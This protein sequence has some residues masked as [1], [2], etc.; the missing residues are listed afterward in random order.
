MPVRDL[1]A[2][3]AIAD[4]PL[5][6]PGVEAVADLFSLDVAAPVDVA[7]T[8]PIWTEEA[9]LI[10]RARNDIR[11]F[12]PLYERNIDRIYRYIYRRVSDHDAA[13]DLTAQTFQQAIAAL[14]SYQ[15]RGVP[16]S[17]W[18]FRIAG[19]LVIRYRRTNG[20]EV[21]MEHVERIVD[22]RGSFEDPLD[23]I[24][25]KARRDL[26]YEAMRQLS[27]DQRRALV[28][29]YVHGLKN[30]EVGERMN[31]TEGGVKQLVH[32]AMIVLRHAVSELEAETAAAD[33]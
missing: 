12:T 9:D 23:A 7:Q 17:A 8:S 11:E 29:K 31:R 24:L 20:R 14:P 32:R 1:A 13:E 25:Q 10:A 22:E 30:H 2:I 15:W 27:D 19:N 28:L 16:F 26:L 3:P 4:A 21:V 5:L 18:L 33:H 6:I